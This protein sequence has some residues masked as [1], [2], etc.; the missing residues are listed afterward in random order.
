MKLETLLRVT[1]LLILAA[2]VGCAKARIVRHDDR[3]DPALPASS[4]G[5]LAEASRAA[6]AGAEPT[7]SA[8][9]MLHRNDEA[10]RWRLLLVDQA[11]ESIDLQVFIWHDD[12]SGNLLVDHLFRAADRGVKVRLLVDEFRLQAPDEALIHGSEHPNLE[13]RIFNPWKERSN[14]ASRLLEMLLRFK[15][16]NQRMHNKLMVA[17][18]RFAIVGGRNVAD[19][20]F[21]IGAG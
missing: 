17:D 10:L 4:S 18:G 8:Y 13:V 12:A 15:K 14:F 1:L 9:A 11:E 6:L 20:Y 7:D 21:G 3:P 2:L 5:A 19:E 16:L